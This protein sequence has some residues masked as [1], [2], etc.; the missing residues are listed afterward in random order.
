MRIYLKICK[1]YI[2]L[3]GKRQKKNV[4]SKAHSFMYHHTFLHTIIVSYTIVHKNTL[5]FF[6]VMSL[7]KYISI[8]YLLYYRQSFLS[9]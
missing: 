6:F 8:Y 2:T 3:I 9:L 1:G 7:I 5:R 4:F